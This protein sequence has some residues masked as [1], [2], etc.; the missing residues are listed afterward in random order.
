MVRRFS[1][2]FAVFSIFMDLFTISAALGWS[3]AIR[4]WLSNFLPVRAV[5]QGP[6]LPPVLYLVFPLLWIGIMALFSIYDG[7]RNLRIVDEFTSLTLSTFL[8]SVSLAGLLY[9]TY[10]EVSRALFLFF[11]TS[12]FFGL[13]LW[14]A[15]VRPLYRRWQQIRQEE[16]KVLVVG[17]GPVGLEVKKR[18]HT[19]EENG[20]RFVG[21]LDDDPLKQSTRPDVLGPLTSAR[22][23]VQERH[24]DDV[25]V[26]LPRRAY[27]R[28]NELNEALRDLPIH[29]WVVPDYFELALHQARLSNLADLPLLDLRAPAIDDYHRLLKR[30]FD[31]VMT[32]LLLL[33]G[34][35]IMGVVALLIWCIDGRPILFRQKRVGENGRLFTLLKFR[36]MIPGA[37]QMLPQIAKTDAQG[38]FIHKYDQDPRVTRLGRL[39]RRF[40]LDEL[41]QLFNILAGDMSLVGP[42]PELPELV[43]RYQPW[44]RE[45]FAVPPG[46]TGWWQIRGRSDKP[47]H[48]H[49]EEDLYYIRNYSF[50]LD[51]YIII[52]TFW[53]V[54]RG[55]G[56][57]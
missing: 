9:L 46:L 30:F 29:L 52:R 50:W 27:A 34:L 31:V 17:A 25:V 51:L 20:L 37:D 45:R 26:A 11:V 12:A 35:P 23:I 39:L 44:Q 55:K 6:L 24:I 3:E 7:S 40:S 32:L 22:Q 5:S 14:R 10:R 36:T 38:R 54:V 19:H 56:A 33:P 18:L 8:A 57:Y 47:M 15:A 2:N 48:L 41:P 49:T 1:V 43:A 16:R 28:V 53:V 13:L 4:P 21:F 42:R